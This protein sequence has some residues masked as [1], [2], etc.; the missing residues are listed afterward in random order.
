MPPKNEMCSL[1]IMVSDVCRHWGGFALTG[2]FTIIVVNN[3][4]EWF[5]TVLGG[6]RFTQKLDTIYYISLFMF[7]WYS[8]FSKRAGI[9]K[10]CRG[11]VE[12]EKRP[13][14]FNIVPYTN[15][16]RCRRASTQRSRPKYEM[17]SISERVNKVL[18]AVYIRA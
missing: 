8:T 10:N 3:D 7:L 14:Y 1:N 11:N 12:F 2:A 17:H 16:F 15:R 9:P 13:L 4:D 5:Q 18:L 6:A